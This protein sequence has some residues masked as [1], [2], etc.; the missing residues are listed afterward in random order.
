MKMSKLKAFSWFKN[1][2]L[3]KKILYAFILSSIIPL[4]IV[5]GITLYV[6]SSSTR[7]KIDEIMKNQLVQ[8]S[9]R[10]SLT[11]DVYTN[12]VYQIYTDETI[13]DD[14]IK[15]MDDQ[16]TGKESIAREIYGRI[17][18]YGTSVD[19]IANI[20]IV[21]SN[22]EYISY[23][24][25][26]ASIVQTLWEDEADLKSIAP[27]QKAQTSN[28]IAITPTTRYVRGGEEERFF[29]LSKRIHDFQSLDTREVGTII[30]SID[31]AVLNK[32]CI[33]GIDTE[34]GQEY[35]VNFITDE[36]R[37]LLCYTD[38]FYAGVPIRQDLSIAEFVQVTGRLKD[39]NVAVN[40]HEDNELG[41]IYYN[42]YDVDYMFRD[43]TRTQ[44]LTVI[45]GLLIMGLSML[46]ILYTIRL[47]N[48]STESILRGIGFVQE[49]QYDNAVK[50]EARDEFGQIAESFNIMTDRVKDSITEVREATIKQKEAEI[51]A[52]EAQINPHFLYNTLDSINW[53]A[54]DK[55]EFEISKMLRDLG[56]ILRYSIDNSNEK[57]TITE[58]ADWLDKYV[59]LQQMRFNHSFKFE[60]H[61][62]DEAKEVRIFKLLIQPFIENAIVHGFKEIAGGGILR[63]DIGVLKADAELVIIIEDNGSGMSQEEVEKYNDPDIK[64]DGRSIGLSNSFSR[65]RMYYGSRASWYVSSIAQ[66]GTVVTLKLPMN[67]EL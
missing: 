57:V 42:V 49:G 32:I 41:W 3:W 60:L 26:N 61:V 17:Q 18:Q 44:Q 13:I 33:S 24:F 25:I 22:G 52:L 65:M 2:K 40:I 7:T 27:Y 62:T 54:I 43:I 9:E 4:L 38:S 23:D 28:G 31:E 67:E 59:G 35:S 39:K 37:N 20:M 16:Q 55:G 11:L 48:K 51:R 34:S 58:A 8:I 46:M 30:M 19:G 36:V 45:I 21:M 1:Q 50:V 5:E 10:M 14:L 15:M 56:V 29:H 66:M 53:M 64:D 6:N 47:I 12:L 63:V